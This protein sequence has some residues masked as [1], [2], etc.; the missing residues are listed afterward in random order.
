MKLTIFLISLLF[1][2]TLFAQ[3]VL[4]LSNTDTGEKLM[5]KEGKKVRVKMKNGKKRTGTMLIFD[6]ESIIVRGERIE[7]DEILKI[8]RHPLLVTILTSVIFG[9][10]GGGAILIGVFLLTTEY[11][12]L[13]APF[14]MTGVPMLYGAVTG[15]NLFTAFKVTDGWNYKIKLQD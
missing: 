8:K 3:D 4:L 5:I 2:Q 7:L 14:L 10:F 9:Y 11:S 1:A 12:V 13:A 6:D 15:M